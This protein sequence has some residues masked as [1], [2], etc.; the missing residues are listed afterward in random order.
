MAVNRPEA[1]LGCGL[2]ATVCPVEM[3]GGH[4]IVSFLAGEETPYSVWLCTSCWRCQEVCPGG[5]DIY[6]LMMEERRRGPAPEG[7]RRAWENVLACGYALC[8]GPE[9]NEVR[10]GWGLEPA[11]LVPPERVRALLEGEERE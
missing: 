5:V 1:C 6:G 11:E 9:V 2:C 10:T 3:V 8:V 7:Y 4:A